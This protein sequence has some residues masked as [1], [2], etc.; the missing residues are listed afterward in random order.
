MLVDLVIII[1]E[2]DIDLLILLFLLV[3]LCIIAHIS[4]EPS[5]S[6][7]MKSYF[8]GVWSSKTLNLSNC[9]ISLR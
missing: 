5:G 8:D 2:P 6:V 7:L 9:S 4:N 1:V 3:K